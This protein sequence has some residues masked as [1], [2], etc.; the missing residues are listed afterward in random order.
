MS[1]IHSATAHSTSSSFLWHNKTYL[2]LAA[3][4][5]I[6]VLIA[7]RFFLKNGEDLSQAPR[8]KRHPDPEPTVDLSKRLITSLFPACANAKQ[9]FTF[10]QFAQGIIR[11]N[12]NDLQLPSSSNSFDLIHIRWTDGSTVF[13]QPMTPGTS[14]QAFIA[15]L[16]YGKEIK[17]EFLYQ[18]QT[19]A[20]V[21][22]TV[23][24]AMGIYE[25]YKEAAEW[26]VESH[27]ENQLIR[28]GL[29]YD[30]SSS[31]VDS[32]LSILIH[33]VHTMGFRDIPKSV[34]EDSYFSFEN[35]SDK[36]HVLFF[37]IASSDAL[38][39]TQN[40]NLVIPIA[41]LPKTTI[42]LPKNFLRACWQFT[43]Y[44]IH[45]ISAPSNSNLFL[46]SLQDTRAS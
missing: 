26:K 16:P 41:I 46:S 4:A 42:I 45:G 10:N 7:Y 30:L 5:G 9:E 33:N 29:Q 19:R 20:E 12:L 38:F 39:S 1:S 21:T 8:T 23:D 28:E 35:T 24:Q 31:K 25:I 37:Q 32:P 40:Q 13:C 34:K 22:I 27:P 2:A 36:T 6:A 18:T 44:S 43:L 3:L 15:D 17:L 11:V 14:L